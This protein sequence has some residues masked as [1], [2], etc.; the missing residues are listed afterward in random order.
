MRG[1]SCCRSRCASCTTGLAK[2]VSCGRV[3]AGPDYL[4]SW[5]TPNIESGPVHLAYLPWHQP[6]SRRDAPCLADDRVSLTY[7]EVD[8]W[9]AAV[10]GQLANHGFGRG[11]VLA[12]MLPNRAELIIAMFAAWRLGGAVTRSTRCSPRPRP[13]TRSSTP[14]PCW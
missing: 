5:I 2:F 13:S 10:A 3:Q 8:D 9:A 11:D 7:A 6:A 1:S 4:V 14:A 12:I